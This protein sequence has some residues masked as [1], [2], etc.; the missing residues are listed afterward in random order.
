[1]KK[2]ELQQKQLA[3]LEDTIKHY[4]LNNR[5]SNDGGQCTYLPFHDKTLGCAIGRHIEDKELCKKLDS[6]RCPGVSSVDTFDLLP[7]NLKE[8]SRLFLVH[9][10]SLHDGFE[11]WNDDGLSKTGI[12][13]VRIIKEL[14]QLD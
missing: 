5:S 3:F 8:L 4:N 9:I 12:E 10:Q 7:D 13:R 1:M 14:Y 11:N 6:L 2:T